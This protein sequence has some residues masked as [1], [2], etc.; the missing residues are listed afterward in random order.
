M[1]NLALWKRTEIKPQRTQRF[2]AE[3]RR[4]LRALHVLWGSDAWRS[5]PGRIPGGRRA[6]RWLLLAVAL[7][8]PTFATA[9]AGR[10][11]PPSGIH[12]VAPV[13][14]VAAPAPGSLLPDTRVYNQL[15]GELARTG[16]LA[17][18]PEGRP[19][20]AG[21][22]ILS[23]AD[24]MANGN[25][26][27]PTA[28][29]CLD[30]N[31]PAKWNGRI[32]Y[33]SY[34]RW[35]T[36]AVDDG[37]FYRAENVRFDMERTVGPGDRQGEF[38]FKIAGGE[39][40]A[41]GLISPVFQV[42]PGATVEARVKYLMFNHPELRVG[43][44]V[45]N[46][47]VSLGLKPDAYG[48]EAVYVNGYARG[49]WSTLANHITAGESGQVLVLIQAE[50]PAPFNSNIYFDDVEIWVDGMPLTDCE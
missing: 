13:P 31:D 36:F 41:A 39:P 30:F 16:E 14:D 32:W 20:E 38:S 22:G 11:L 49:Q 7:A 24:G 19:M 23:R 9:A 3:K 43:G 26:L 42:P 15:A 48:P 34:G 2:H 35:G 18:V 45:V 46:D 4:L 40:Y 21:P 44:R 33:A 47:W 28:T 1:P 37:G 10:P 27:F 29:A 50:S 6:V 5:F 25:T 17:S 8:W 12:A